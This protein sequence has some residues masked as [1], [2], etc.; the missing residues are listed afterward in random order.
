MSSH[1]VAFALFHS[2]DYV[3]TLSLI[4]PS[5]VE[6]IK[7]VNLD[8]MTPRIFSKALDLLSD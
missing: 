5:S 4:S 7:T 3:V 2:C 6:Y 1:S 8:R